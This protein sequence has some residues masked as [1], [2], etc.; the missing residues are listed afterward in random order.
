MNANHEPKLSQS[1][2]SR[3]PGA[4][5]RGRDVF[6]VIL[7]ATMA[8]AGGALVAGGCTFIN[9]FEDLKPHQPDSGGSDSGNPDTPGIDTNGPDT[10]GLDTADTNVDP[11]TH[12]L[13]V[14]GG[15]IAA[16]AGVQQV[17]RALNPATGEAY[18]GA[19]E[20]MTVVH[21]MYDGERDL[22]YIFE[23]T[24]ASDRVQPAP[25]DKVTLHVREWDYN[26]GKWKADIGT[27]TD[28]P[29][30]FTRD[31]MAVLTEEIA[32]VAFNGSSG[33]SLVLINTHTPG[34]PA[35]IGTPTTLT[36]SFPI[37]FIG[38]RKIGGPGG[39]VAIM[40]YGTCT[41][42]GV[43][44]PVNVDHFTCAS[45]FAPPNLDAAL[46]KTLA[47][48]DSKDGNVSFG[49]GTDV[50][51]SMLVTTPYETTADK[52]GTIQVLNPATFAA[53]TLKFS[54]EE[55]TK[56]LRGTAVDECND[57]VLFIPELLSSSVHVVPLTKPDV[58]V[59]KA[60][61]NLGQSVVWEPFTQTMLAPFKQGVDSD[62]AAFSFSQAAD[63]TPTLSKRT[64]DW[65]YERVLRPNVVTTK[66]PTSA[67]FKCPK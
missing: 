46:S 19:N 37:G 23:N 36:G 65:K 43:G 29:T 30:P 44:C 67:G 62:I 21:A 52:H 22:W 9:S 11:T 12:G 51:N 34:A 15:E 39:Y 14:V 7:L 40:R 63:K 42:T 4:R 54:M 50:V 8:T 41:A 32:Y 64:G 66:S 1:N 57:G 26:A 2:V 55:S 56:F 48:I 45:T 13:V 18:P 58:A 24:T 27:L 31:A 59:T 3:R 47:T 25:G 38:S 49:I 35:L 16:D 28:I 5:F 20:N 6:G 33:T 53:T 61:G 17:L 60:L 10:P